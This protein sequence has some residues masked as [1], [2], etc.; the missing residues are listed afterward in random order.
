MV[1]LGYLL[2]TSAGTGVRTYAEVLGR[3][4][5]SSSFL[6]IHASGRRTCRRYLEESDVNGVVK[7]T[8]SLNTRKTIIR[9]KPEKNVSTTA[10]QPII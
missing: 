5:E 2:G 3:F 9:S 1:P 6:G 7:Q 10:T 4:S 8:K